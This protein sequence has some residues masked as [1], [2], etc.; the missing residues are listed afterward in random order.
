L[1]DALT[2]DERASLE[3]WQAVGIVLGTVGM[4]VGAFH[5]YARN[6]SIGWAL[7][8]GA[9]GA[10]APVVVVPIALAQGLGTPRRGAHFR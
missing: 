5:G 10:L 9:L 4:G 7:A 6:R 8:W 1:A 2:P 3:R